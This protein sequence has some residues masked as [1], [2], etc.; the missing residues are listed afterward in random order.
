M[1]LVI[2]FNYVNSKEWRMRVITHV[3]IVDESSCS[4]HVYDRYTVC[5]LLGVVYVLMET[6]SH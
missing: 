3:E 4:F 2:I 5:A 1:E 6:L